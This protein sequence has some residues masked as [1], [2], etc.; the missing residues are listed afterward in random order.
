MVLCTYV[1]VLKPIVNIKAQTARTYRNPELS[2]G[3]DVELWFPNLIIVIFSDLYGS[4]GHKT[5]LAG[6]VIS[7]VASHF[8]SIYIYTSYFMLQLNTDFA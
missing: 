1:F 6:S 3:A 4:V 8:V 5:V 2:L 7:G